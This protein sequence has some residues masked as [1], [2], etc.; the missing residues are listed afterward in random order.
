MVCDQHLYHKWHVFVISLFVSHP[1]P[2]MGM[3]GV[4]SFSVQPGGS[5]LNFPAILSEGS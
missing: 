5:L 2:P 1:Q 3:P 4:G